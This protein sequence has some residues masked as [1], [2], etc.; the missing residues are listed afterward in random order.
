MKK[1]KI[2]S[3]DNNDSFTDRQKTLLELRTG[4]ERQFDN[5]ISY[6]SGGAL[7]FSMM[8]VKDVIGNKPQVTSSW[9]LL[10]SWL[11]FLSSLITNMYSH[12]T[13]RN[14]AEHGLNGENI[15]SEN[16]DNATKVLNISSEILLFLGLIL[17]IIY[18]LINFPL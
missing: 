13:A 7:V 11:I 2:K 18:V 6:L 14:A 15:K 3:N 17:F 1:K 9:I 16:S 5:Y 4:A 10:L 12:R 8:F